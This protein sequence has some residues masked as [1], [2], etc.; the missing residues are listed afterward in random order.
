MSNLAGLENLDKIGSLA[1]LESFGDAI[2][3]QDTSLKVLYQNQRHRE[4]MGAHVGRFCHEAFRRRDTACP[5]CHLLKSFKHGKSHRRETSIEHP[6]RGL[7]HVE[8]VSTPLHDSDGS[9]FAGIESVRDITERKLMSE[10]LNAITSD[11]EQRTWKL[12]AA[13]KGLESFSYMLSHDVRNYIARI[14]MA[15][16]ALQE[17]C[18]AVLD[19][20]GDMLFSVIDESC[21][22]LELL[23]EAIL[24]LSSSGQEQIAAEPVDLTLLAAEVAQ[25]L[26]V[27]FPQRAVSV[28]IAPGMVA[29]GDSQLLKIALHNL[30]G[31]AWKYTGNCPAPLVRFFTEVRDG[32]TVFVVR[33]NGCGFDM[34]ESARLFKPFSRLSSGQAAKG[35]GIGLATVRRVV[36]SHGGDIWGNG[37]LGKGATFYFTLAPKE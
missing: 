27:Q 4:L 22:E 11:I 3:I 32:K 13:N 35:T 8:I 19:G 26:S 24:R 21:S 12:M 31:N 2:S 5:G 25:E 20:T 10:K 14:S 30:F 1:I 34:K 36:L 29:S 33:D 23:V 7:V 37:E 17:E 15:S 16:Q 9:V 6:T 18:P 28:D